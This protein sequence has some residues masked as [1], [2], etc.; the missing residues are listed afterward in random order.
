MKVVVPYLC[1][2]YTNHRLLLPLI[3]II[4]I[5]LLQVELLLLSLMILTGIAKLG[6]RYTLLKDCMMLIHITVCRSYGASTGA[7]CGTSWNRVS[8]WI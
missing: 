3:I 2:L 6:T 7:G 4:I 5:V 8:G 1:I